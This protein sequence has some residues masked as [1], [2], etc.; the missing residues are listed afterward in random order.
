MGSLWLTRIFNQLGDTIV[1][2][3]ITIEAKS[4]DVDTVSTKTSRHKGQ[5][6]VARWSALAVIDIPRRYVL[7][8]DDA[9][10]K[11]GKR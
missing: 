4:I 2:E 1:G 7:E 9:K 8:K 11:R 6:G 3:K 5:F 10:K